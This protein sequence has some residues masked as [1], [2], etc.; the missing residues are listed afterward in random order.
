MSDSEVEGV[1]MKRV[2]PLFFLNNE[3]DQKEKYLDTYEICTAVNVVL[4]KAKLING[5]QR[6]GGL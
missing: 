3:A 2:E 6:F 1:G 4:G 5:A